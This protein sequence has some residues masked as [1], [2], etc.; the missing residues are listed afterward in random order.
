MLNNIIQIMNDFLDFLNDVLKSSTEP[1]YPS[2]INN[3]EDEKIMK[4]EENEEL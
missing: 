3:N 2:N 1:F 4:K